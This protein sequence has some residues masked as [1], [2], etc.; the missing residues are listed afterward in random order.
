VALAVDP[1]TGE[2]EERPESNLFRNIHVE[3]PFGVPP[4][5]RSHGVAY[6]E[7]AEYFDIPSSGQRLLAGRQLISGPVS[8]AAFESGTSKF[9]AELRDFES[10]F[11][12]ALAKW[13]EAFAKSFTVG[14][15]PEDDR[16]PQ[17]TNPRRRDDPPS[18]AMSD[19]TRAELDAKLDAAA[20]RTEAI[21]ARI[22]GKIDVMSA[23][24]H[25]LRE[26][27]AEL[28]EDS[29]SN[30]AL[31]IGSALTIFLTIIATAWAVYSGLA[32]INL[33]LIQS[34]TGAFSA[35]RD[36]GQQI[37]QAKGQTPPTPP[38]AVK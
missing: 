19:L 22:E 7:S 25:G 15:K 12:G 9:V 10:R 34:V 32:S 26:S 1:D 23:E 38:A 29:R 8:A 31:L 33:G 21:V 20:A 5:F 13:Q 36:V 3:Q 18:S 16:D 11:L 14:T 37:E 6:P 17:S 35:G 28:R 2:L 4:S 30:R 24:V 27:H